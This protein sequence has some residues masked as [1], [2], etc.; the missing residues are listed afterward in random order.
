[1]VLVDKLWFGRIGAFLANGGGAAHAPRRGELLVFRSPV[2]YATDYLIKRV[3]G[4]S[5]DQVAI[6]RGR[7][8]VNGKPIEEPYVTTPY[9]ETFSY[10]GSGQTVQ[11]PEGQFFVLGDNRADSF[12]SHLGWTVPA[13]DVIGR[14]WLSYWPPSSWGPIP[15]A[16]L[17][18]PT[19]APRDDDSSNAAASRLDAVVVPGLPVLL[20]ET[21]EGTAARWPDNPAIG[22]WPASDGYHLQASP[23]RQLVAIRAPVQMPLGDVAVSARLRRVAGEVGGSYGLIVREERQRTS[24]TGPARGGSF[25]LVAVNSLGEVGVWRFAD[26]GWIDL[27]PWTRSAAVRG[28]DEG[29]LLSVLAVGP[30]LTFSVNGVVVARLTDRDMP[31]SG[32]VGVAVGGSQTEAVVDRFVVQGVR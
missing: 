8:V 2:P 25:E 26:G 19:P 17:S 30:Q 10:P 23:S 29:N 9:P 7:L 16:S 6:E 24:A 12:D 18:A 11:V 4:L 3:I 22:T 27:L 28:V 1:L 13:G 20:D 15:H 31:A 14:A 5:G 21:F 32:A